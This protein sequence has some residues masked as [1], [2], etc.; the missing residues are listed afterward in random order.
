MWV[1]CLGLGQIN[2][3]SYCGCAE[4]NPVVAFIFTIGGVLLVCRKKPAGSEEHPAQGKL[5]P[6]LHFQRLGRLL[7]EFPMGAKVKFQLKK[8]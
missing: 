2:A 3:K 6:Q 1:R 7:T 4:R 8:C 5:F